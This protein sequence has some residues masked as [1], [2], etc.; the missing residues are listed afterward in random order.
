MFPA[1]LDMGDI[2]QVF[3]FSHKIEVVLENLNG[4]IIKDF[5][6]CSFCRADIENGFAFA[7]MSKIECIEFYTVAKQKAH[8]FI[9]ALGDINQ[10]TLG[11]GS[12]ESM[13]GDNIFQSTFTFL[14]SKLKI[15]SNTH[16]LKVDDAYDKYLENPGDSL[17]LKWLNVRNEIDRFKF[18]IANRVF[19]IARLKGENV[20]EK[21][22]MAVLHSMK[23][24]GPSDF[25]IQ[26][27]GIKQNSG[28]KV[29]IN[30]CDEF[31]KSPDSQSSKSIF[32]AVSI[33]SDEDINVLRGC[34]LER[35]HH[36]DFT[37]YFFEN[38]GETVAFIIERNKGKNV[39]EAY[40]M[41]SGIEYKA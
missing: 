10:K 32:Y 24:G 15:T 9:Y 36:E 40:E 2:F 31:N 8:V 35:N 38:D 39:E 18:D 14:D 20:V 41:F 12:V 33:A 16:D 26:V 21:C 11:I 27:E 28:T 37:T 34:K 25:F 5:G 1:P 22:P 29:Q 6:D 3:G 30:V 13:M 19:S 17:G 4:E 7:L 23:M